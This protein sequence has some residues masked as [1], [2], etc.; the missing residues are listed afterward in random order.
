MI[1]FLLDT[2]VLS[3]MRRLRPGP[4]V[5]NFLEAQPESLLSS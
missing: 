3:E 1:G 5:L 4:Q 2:N